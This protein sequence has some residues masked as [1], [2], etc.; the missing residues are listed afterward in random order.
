MVKLVV[1]DIDNT[2][3]PKHKQPSEGT[4]KCIKEFNER[5]ILFGFASGRSTDMLRGL[6]DQWGI[7]CDILIGN[8]GGE[9][10]D[11]ITGEHDIYRKLSCE[12][13]EEIFKIMEPFKDQ[14]NVQ[15]FVD[16]VRYVRRLDQQTIDSVRYRNMA[17]P[18][19]VDDESIFWS[20]PAY[21]VGFRTPAEIMEAVEAQVA[22]YPNRSFKGFKTEFTMF[23]FTPVECEKGDML[24]RF[25]KS[26][27]IPIE[28]AW[29]F[30][31]MTNDVSLIRDAGVGVC[32]ENGSEDAKAV[33]DIITEE[34][35]E[36]DGFS[37][38]VF[39]HILNEN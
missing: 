16:G 14:V 39:K 13:L 15:M 22:K 2:L 35:I 28:D 36:D 27:N 25:C 7:R 19:V 38:F 30:G 1:C 32:L 33:A 29:A 18:V 4:L 21:K 24:V 23:E 20:K 34:S 5:G 31:D 10:Q 3:V 26:H 9:Y 12:E 11:E 37:K 17:M 6:A 8:N